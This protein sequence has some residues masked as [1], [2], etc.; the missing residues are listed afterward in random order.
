MAVQISLVLFLL[1]LRYV[2][3]ACANHTAQGYDPV[4]LESEDKLR[5]LYDSW[6][7]T[8]GVRRR[9]PSEEEKRFAIFKDNVKY[10]EKHNKL[11]RIN[12]NN[13]LGLNQFADMSREEFKSRTTNSRI[14]EDGEQRTTSDSTSRYSRKT[15][16]PLLV[17]WRQRGAVTGVKDQGRCGSGWAFS[18]TGAVEGINK[19]TTGSLVSLSEQE[20]LD[21]VAG[22][23]GCDGG[24]RVDQAFQFM[25]DNGGIGT[26]DD[27]PYNANQE[28]CNQDI[29][30][31]RAVTIDGYEYVP[32]NNEGELKK[33]VAHQPVS[34]MIEATNNDLQFYSS[35]VFI[36]KCGSKID[37][38][39]L[40]VGYGSRNGR[41]F[42]LV[43][44]SWGA[45]WGEKGYLRI[46]R[47]G[48]SVNGKC[49]IATMPSF[50]VKETSRCHSSLVCPS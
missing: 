44:N 33:A 38:A 30:N 32:A 25:I 10:I 22:N 12:N 47:N 41:P 50:P 6:A 1:G 4:D 26:E 40:I 29:L 39:V 15:K 49:G 23:S 14:S 8:H 48:K 34:T 45:S 3:V 27:C 16:L 19:I 37:H 20:L 18:S 35:G 17:D 5:A 13:L 36:G 9:S 42:W 28:I 31:S 21:C 43:K 24:G 2:I 7:V 11:A 46:E